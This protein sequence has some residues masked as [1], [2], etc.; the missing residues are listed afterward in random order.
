MLTRISQVSGAGSSCEEVRRTVVVDR[1]KCCK[2]PVLLGDKGDVSLP[3]ETPADL[4]QTFCLR[5]KLPLSGPGKEP[6][7]TCCAAPSASHRTWWEKATGRTMPVPAPSTGCRWDTAPV[8]LSDMSLPCQLC[9]RLL[10]RCG[11]L[12][13]LPLEPWQRFTA[14]YARGHGDGFYRNLFPHPVEHYKRN[15]PGKAQQPSWFVQPRHLG[16]LLNFFIWLFL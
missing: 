9:Q 2:T 13:L 11:H 15:Y 7:L 12:R 1:T 10:R 4:S 14:H 8:C 16:S 6:V 3:R 5:Q